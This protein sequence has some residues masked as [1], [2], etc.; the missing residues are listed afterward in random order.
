MTPTTPGSTLLNTAHISGG[1]FTTEATTSVAVRAS[2]Q[3]SLRL[4]K[5]PSS[6]PATVSA[7]LVYT[8]AYSL[9]GAAGVENV[10]ITDA[11]PPGVTAVS[12]SDG[13]VVS[14]ST[15]T[16]R[17]G[18]LAPGASGSVTV[19]M[20]MP[21]TPGVTVLNTAHISGGSFEAEA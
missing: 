5:T 12:A 20:T 2:D 1:N 11:L 9:V 21:D 3:S 14:G 16:W 8:L 13:G 17:L 4:T 15:V 6:N 19:M 10:I 18:N 7:P